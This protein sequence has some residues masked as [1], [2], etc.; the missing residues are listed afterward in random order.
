METPTSDLKI[1]HTQ[2]PVM[3]AITA[4]WSPRSFSERMITLEELSTLVEAATWAPSSINEQ[5]WQYLYAMRGSAEFQQ[6]FDFLVPGN[7]FWAGNASVILLS[8]ARKNFAGNG[9]ANRHAMYDVG[10][11][12]A[13]LLLQ[14]ASMGIYGHQMGGFDMAK[15][16]ETLQLPDHLE[17]AC[18]IALGFLDTPDKLEEP[19]LTRELTPR[20]RKSVQEV[21]SDKPNW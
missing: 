14:G 4:R 10:A 5:P 1:P 9:N 6:Y 8:L 17:I 11:A 18:F 21:M 16:R 20:S 15:A 19:F 12:N 13:Q 7:K 2:F 3:P